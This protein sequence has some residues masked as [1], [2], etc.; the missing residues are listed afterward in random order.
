MRARAPRC[1]SSYVQ[2]WQLLALGGYSLI[3]MS[4]T[5][6]H[7]V[8]TSW[9]ADTRACPRPGPSKAPA[10]PARTQN[11][12]NKRASGGATARTLSSMSSPPNDACTSTLAGVLLRSSPILKTL[13]A[14]RRVVSASAVAIGAPSRTVHHILKLV[15]ERLLVQ[16]LQR[17]RTS[18]VACSRDAA[19]S[20]APG[21]RCRRRVCRPQP[22]WSSAQTR[23][24]R[25]PMV[26]A[27]NK[28]PKHKSVRPARKRAPL[29][30]AHL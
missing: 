8:R 15:H 4:G 25:W 7:S 2:A 6:S 14:T 20:G 9:P 3:S 22:A 13:P 24:C 1:R 26:A 11:R 19:A 21:R 28:P 23:T 16:A 10:H 17:A 30:F 27:G 18:V 12:Q 5:R 29:A